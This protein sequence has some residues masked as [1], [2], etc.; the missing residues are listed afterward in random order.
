MFTYNLSEFFKIKTYIYY[1]I[2]VDGALNKFF[3]HIIYFI[4]LYYIR[5]FVY[6]KINYKT[7]HKYYNII[8][9]WVILSRYWVWIRSQTHVY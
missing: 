7:I 2:K 9:F 4:Y 5:E 3:I 8:L 1:H 6:N